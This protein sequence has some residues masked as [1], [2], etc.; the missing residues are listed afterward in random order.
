MIELKHRR[1]DYC[2]SVS[3]IKEIQDHKNKENITAEEVLDFLLGN[4]ENWNEGDYFVYKY[5]QIHY[6]SFM[7]RLNILWVYPLFVLSIPM[8]W[9]IKGSIGVNRNSKIGRIID[10][11]IK[12]DR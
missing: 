2:D 3:I 7:Q 4:A 1:V 6:R 12:F 10:Y 11:L 9:L 5:D 8:Q